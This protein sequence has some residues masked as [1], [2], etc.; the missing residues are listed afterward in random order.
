MMNAFI[1][2]SLMCDVRHLFGLQLTS[3]HEHQQIE[4]R[5]VPTC[6]VLGSL[7]ALL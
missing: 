1:C 7:V 3:S 6:E 4:V 2:T 5:F